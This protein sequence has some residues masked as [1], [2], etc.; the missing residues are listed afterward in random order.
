MLEIEYTKA[1]KK[2]EYLDGVLLCRFCSNRCEL[3]KHKYFKK[4]FLDQEYCFRDWWNCDKCKQI[5]C[6]EKSRCFPEDLQKELPS[7]E[8]YINKNQLKLC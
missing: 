7:Y 1:G 6:N 4:G 2:R 3:K 5:F 8:E